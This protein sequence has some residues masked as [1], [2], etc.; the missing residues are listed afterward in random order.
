MTRSGVWAWDSRPWPDFQ[1]R[2]SLWSDGIN[3]NTGHWISGRF[4]DQS[5]AAVVAEICEISNVFDYDVGTL[6]GSVAGFATRDVETGRQSLQSL[7]IA[8]DFMS[9]EDGGRII[10]AHQKQDDAMHFPESELAFLPDQDDVVSKTRSPEAERV[11]RLRVQFWDKNAHFEAASVETRFIGDLSQA[12]SSLQLPLVLDR[13]LG[14]TIANRLFSNA[15]VARDEVKFALPPSNLDIAL[16]DYISIGESPFTYRVDRIEDFGARLVEGVRVER[17]VYDAVSG[18]G[19][20]REPVP[21]PTETTPHFAFLDLPL[22]KGSEAAH[23]PHF[24]ATAVPWGNGV[25]VYNSSSV[26][27]FSLNTVSEIPAVFGDTLSVLP[28]SETMRWDRGD[29]VLVKFSGDIQARGELDVLNGANA[30]AIR[31]EQGDWEVFQFSGADLQADGSYRL[32]DLLRGQAGTEWVMP[33]EWPIGS[34]IVI[35]GE[36]VGQIELAETARGLER[37]YRIGPARKPVSNEGYVQVTET[38]DGV[39]LRPYTPVHLRR[40]SDGIGGVQ[41]N[42]IRRTRIDGDNW[43]SFEVP[44]G[45]DLERYHLRVW[46]EGNLLR[47][48]ETTEP[49]WNYTAGEIAT[50]GAN[51]AVDIEVAQLSGRFGIGPYNRMTVNV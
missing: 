40:G 9:Y 3:Y 32:T 2:L 49:A 30:A 26:D 51:G 25:A 8:Y 47:E 14:Q 41:V 16:G 29:G 18:N 46:K 19:L 38:F 13:E 23:A 50:D 39:G 45:E 28:R 44:L 33:E 31:F 10:F 37:N 12:T 4:A 35:L 5:L 1:D 34:E 15:K 11:G 43:Q 24:A 27:G 6:R 7:M 42:W 36:G 48:T 17:G 22:L 21:V 20:S